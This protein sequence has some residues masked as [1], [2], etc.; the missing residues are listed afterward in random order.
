ML[1][2]SGTPLVVLN[3]CD[4]ATSDDTDVSLAE[5]LVRSGVGTAIGMQMPISD[6][7]AGHFAV[8]LVGALG[9]GLPVDVAVTQGRRRVADR[10]GFSEWG[11]PTL[12][13]SSRVE[14]PIDG[15][16]QPRTRS[17]ELVGA[18]AGSGDVARGGLS[19][20]APRT[21]PPSGGASPTRRGRGPLVGAIAVF[22]IALLGAGFWLLTGDDGEDTAA[23]PTVAGKVE[24]QQ[25]QDTVPESYLDLNGWFD[26][27]LLTSGTPSPTS[28]A[29]EQLVAEWVGY[30]SV[31]DPD[32]DSESGR[33]TEPK[34]LGLPGVPARANYA[35]TNVERNSDCWKV[36][37]HDLMVVGAAGR[38]LGLSGG[39][40]AALRLVEFNDET[41]AEQ[42]FWATTMN[43]GLKDD[44]CRGWPA[45]TDMGSIAVDPERLEIRRR[46]F[47][48]PTEDVG[49]PDA[50]LT[51][52][53]DNV[54]L[55][56]LVLRSAYVG[57]F[58]YDE[59]VGLAVMGSLTDPL[60]ENDAKSAITEAVRISAG[61]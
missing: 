18:G 52:K 8:G 39:R 9:E 10:A 47:S 5:Q 61:N 21:P 12:V 54:D 33:K 2:R 29:L 13:S 34:D 30:L 4:T 26:P 28:A 7:N 55:E 11:I 37:L 14:E 3:A 50:L 56:S 41:D 60:N 36:F 59:V 38:E 1:L 40:V 20:T 16:T 51:A 25:P 42:F 15:V 43:A 23:D 35:A 58:R 31:V 44:E 6:S 46:D 32:V 53:G 27:E 17:G 48:I 57:V 45:A 24:E 49:R 22:V 19:T